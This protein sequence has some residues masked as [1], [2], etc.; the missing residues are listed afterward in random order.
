MPR[1]SIEGL[2]LLNELVPTPATP[3]KE[4]GPHSAIEIAKENGGLS[5]TSRKSEKIA[6]ARPHRRVLLETRRAN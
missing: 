5:A 6:T 2:R 3:G 1:L 4:D